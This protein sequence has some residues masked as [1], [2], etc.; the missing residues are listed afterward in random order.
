MSRR[1]IITAD[2]Y[3]LCEPANAAIEEC[4][5]AGAM[6]ATCVMTNMPDYRAV[7]ALRHRFPG[8]SL[9]IH[10]TL[11]LGR[12]VLPPQQV[13]SLVGPGGEFLHWA[14][15]RRRVL[16]RKIDF[17]QVRA[18]LYAQVERF[19]ETA[20]EPD[21]WNTHQNVH[22]APGLFQTCVGLAH[23][24][25]ITTMRSHRR[26]TVPQ[27]GG[28]LGY[29]LRHPLYWLKA[30]LIGRWTDRAEALGMRTPDGI[31]Y[32]PGFGQGRTAVEAVAERLPWRNVRQAAEWVIHPATTTDHPLF[33]R[34]TESRLREDEV[35]RDPELKERLAGRG[36][37]CVGFEVLRPHLQ[38]A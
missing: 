23:E 27:Q 32:T 9:G 19:R 38:P 22:V 26:I 1:L 24:L 17:A 7:A 10:W 13:P 33:G 37:M 6:H 30:Q 16:A 29:N 14:E 4:L 11:S 5:E 2:D 31:I 20:G 21:F 35:F 15:L 28:A 8:A 18:E 25:G 34:L 36:V 3:G 12:P